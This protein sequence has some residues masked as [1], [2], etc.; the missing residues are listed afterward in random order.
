MVSA[1]YERAM[2]NAAVASAATLPS[3]WQVERSMS[4]GGALIN[5]LSAL[6]R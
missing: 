3:A 5:L 6:F 4:S 2:A 1:A